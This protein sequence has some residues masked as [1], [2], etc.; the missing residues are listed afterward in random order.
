MGNKLF[1]IKYLFQFTDGTRE[2]FVIDINSENLVLKFPDFRPASWTKLDFYQCP[3]CPLADSSAQY[4]PAAMA[5]QNTIEIFSERHSYEEVDVVVQVP[6]RTYFKKTSLQEGLRS[7]LGILMPVSGCPGLAPLRPM[8][9]FHLPFATAKE[10]LF[11]SA[12]SYLVAQ[13][14]RN[15]QRKSPDWQLGKMAQ[16][17]AKIH[18]IN[19]HFA[20]RIHAVLKKDAAANS[21]VI[22][23]IFAQ[24]IPFSI[25]LA[26]TEIKSFYKMYLD[27]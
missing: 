15:L 5:I 7:M 20:K 13:Y 19:I 3:E 10:T 17:Y 12:G 4:C 16:M 8:V 14:F 24:S 27:E 18:D 25:D 11:R 6:A 9:R 23:D 26:L 22:L 1:Q 21:I 2:K